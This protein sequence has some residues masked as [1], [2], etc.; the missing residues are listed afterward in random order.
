MGIWLLRMGTIRS[1]SGSAHTPSTSLLVQMNPRFLRDSSLNFISRG[2]PGSGWMAELQRGE[3]LHVGSSQIPRL[4]LWGFSRS[5][6]DTQVNCQLRTIKTIGFIQQ[7]L[8][9]FL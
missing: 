6:P 4:R 9:F 8:S 2:S 5:A 1:G 3:F 7:G